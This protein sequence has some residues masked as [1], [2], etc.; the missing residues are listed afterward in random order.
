MILVARSYLPDLDYLL[1]L[2]FTVEYI[3]I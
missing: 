3:K 2:H 1:P